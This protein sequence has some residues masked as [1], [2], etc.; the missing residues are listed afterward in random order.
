MVTESIVQT[1]LQIQSIFLSKVEHVTSSHFSSPE[2]K[3]QVSFSAETCSLSFVVD[4]V[5]VVIVNLS[6]FL[7]SSREPLSQFQSNLAQRI[8]NRVMPSSKGR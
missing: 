2:S 1:Y 4:D 6:H 5:V 3:A 8:L 7:S